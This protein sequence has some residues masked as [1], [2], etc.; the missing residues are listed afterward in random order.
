[1]IP[2]KNRKT[3]NVFKKVLWKSQFRKSM[4][5]VNFE[6]TGAEHPADPFHKILK[7]LEILDM[8]SISVKKHEM[9]I[10]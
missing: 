4:C 8:R 2:Q 5:L 1:M 10:K 6:K 3:W 9:D 7:I